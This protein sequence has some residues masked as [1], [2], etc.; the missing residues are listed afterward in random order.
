MTQEGHEGEVKAQEEQGENANSLHE[1]SHVSNRHMTWWRNA[2]W[3]RVNNGPH[4]Q[5]ARDRRRVWAS[6]HQGRAGSAR[7]GKGPRGRKGE[8][9]AREDRKQHPARHFLL[10]PNSRSSCSIGSNSASAMT[11][12]VLAGTER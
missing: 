3:V 9:G 10:Q 1:E 12:E 4:L 7:H 11:Q 2:W 8:M 5:T 6:S